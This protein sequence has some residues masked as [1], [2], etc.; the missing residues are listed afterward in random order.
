MSS[1]SV[2][3]G[4]Q[5][6][7]SQEWLA[8]RK[9]LL[10][11]EKEWTRMRDELSRMRRELPWE[12]VEKN[13]VF[14]GPEGKVT[15]AELFGE[16][17]QLVIYH[18][19]FGPSW[20]QGCPSCSMV[21]DGFDGAMVHVAD[22]D[23]ML[24][25]VSRATLPE[26]EAFRKRM[27][28]KFKWVSSNGN[29]FNHDYHVSFTKEEVEKGSM[30][31][32]YAINP[33]PSEEGPGVSV[34]YKDES[35]EVFHTYSTFARGGEP[36]IGAYAYLDLAPKGRNEEGLSFPMAWVRHHDRYAGAPVTKAS[37]CA[38]DHA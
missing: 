13:Y 9:A 31:Y 23:V 5:V 20:E 24:M 12:R 29:D 1:S 37:C 36:L 14:E 38:G 25:A 30:Y 21:A 6:A 19:M 26:I 8:A 11:K 34:F 16:K 27:G 17:S 3:L 15:L 33:F 28:W 18:F 4:H 2:D 32:N 7:S 22:R 10:A 35:G